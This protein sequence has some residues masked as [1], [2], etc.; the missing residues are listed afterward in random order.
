M[1]KNFK[2][3]DRD[4][5]SEFKKLD[6]YASATTKS[7]PELYAAYDFYLKKFDFLLKFSQKNIFKNYIFSFDVSYFLSHFITYDN[8]A[9]T[10]TG[11]RPSLFKLTEN[12]TFDSQQLNNLMANQEVLAKL[13]NFETWFEKPFGVL[14][15][16]EL[17]SLRTYKSVKQLDTSSFS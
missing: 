1:D 5:T 6:I 4:L 15:K 17:H 12:Y 3:L 13:D 10:L 14:D 9:P 2:F 16:L 11:Q 7:N 8:F